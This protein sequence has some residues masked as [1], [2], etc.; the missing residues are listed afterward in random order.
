M[1][2]FFT[3][4]YLATSAGATLLVTMVTQFVKQIEWEWF[5][6]IPVQVIAYVVALIGIILGTHFTVGLTAE[7]VCIAFVNAIVVTVAANGTYDNIVQLLQK[8]ETSSKK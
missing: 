1:E 5:K 4:E 7:S 2:G 6:K 3:W 8:K